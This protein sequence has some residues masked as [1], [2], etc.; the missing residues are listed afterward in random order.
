MRRQ[1]GFTLIELMITLAIAAILLTI[2]VPG[3]RELMVNNRL[4]TQSN[5]LVSAFQLARSEAVKRGVPVTVCSSADQATCTLNNDWTT[6]W[7][8]FIDN[9]SGGNP[10]V[11]TV[12]RVWDGLSADANL[13][14]T[15]DD[16]DGFVRYQ[17]N[18]TTGENNTFIYNINGCRGNQQ[19]TISVKLSGIV[20]TARS[21]CP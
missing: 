19:R 4:A 8:L 14:E 21:A 3:F 13:D 7:I 10:S 5:E 6:G 16:T 20:S 18:G 17:V 12:L 15:D 1:S 11:N 2:G 9:N